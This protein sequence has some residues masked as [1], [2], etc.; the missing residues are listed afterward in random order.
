MRRVLNATQELMR[1]LISQGPQATFHA[2]HE[3]NALL[4]NQWSKLCLHL[5]A[6]LNMLGARRDSPLNAI[7]KVLGCQNIAEI[8]FDQFASNEFKVT[9]LLA[10]FSCTD[11]SDLYDYFRYFGD[12]RISNALRI[13][14]L[15]KS[16]GEQMRMSHVSPDAL[17]AALELGRPKLVINLLSE[18]QV[19]LKDREH[20]REVKAMAHVL[21][22]D[23]AAANKLWEQLFQSSDH[24]FHQFIKGRSIAVV[25]P[26]P[27]SEEIG[28]EIDSYDLVVRTNYRAGSN[29]P[30]N[31]YGTRTNISYYNHYRM[32][33]H[34]DEVV[35]AA[36]SLD[37]IIFKSQSDEAKFR[38]LL[39]TYEGGGRSAFLAHPIFFGDAAP[40]TIQTIMNDLIRFS[41]GNI[42]LFCNSF[43]C[44]E[45]TYNKG[46]R[47]IPLEDSTISE[48][49]RIHELFS[50]FSFVRNLHRAGLCSVDCLTGEILDL[51]LEQ[52]AKNI[53]G[54][55]GEFLCQ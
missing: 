55:Y 53:N 35:N 48:N 6:R 9:N 11:I 37:W 23:L 45:K 24:L 27:P 20:V 32:S 21:L 42:K 41:P 4:Q 18:K 52:Y 36:S 8:T 13:L 5:G 1:V 7:F 15:E 38:N 47:A 50:G 43:Y 49:L 22:G 16:V 28:A 34:C 33:S 26:T 44:S 19:R 46:Y 51:S 3:Y 30:V 39:P 25:G 31:L 10:D 29:N 17:N 40:M 2:Y 12:F 14:M 54:L